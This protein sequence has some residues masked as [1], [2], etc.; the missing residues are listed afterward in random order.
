[1][2]VAAADVWKFTP[3]QRSREREYLRRAEGRPGMAMAGQWTLV[4]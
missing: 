4:R 3:G 1:M 2:A